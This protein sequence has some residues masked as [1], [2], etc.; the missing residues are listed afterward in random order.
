MK[1][2]LVPT[3]F[4]EASEK[5]MDY[6]IELAKCINAELILLHVFH[7][8]VQPT[9]APIM[10]FSIDDLEKDNMNALSAFEKKFKNKY[11]SIKTGLLVKPGFVVDE[12]LSV[13]QQKKVDLILMGVTGAGKSANVLLGSNTTFLMKKTK[14]P[15]LVIPQNA[16]FKE[17]KNIALAYDYKN[18]IDDAVMKKFIEFVTLFK[19]KVFVL[20]VL[21]PKTV[22][23]YQEAISGLTMENYLKNIDHGLFFP[24]S[25]NI[26]DEMNIFVD[27]HQIDWLV[28]L[29]QSH[30]LLTGLFHRSN[31]KRM[32]FHTH[33]PLLS[34]H[35]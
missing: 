27:T 18:V 3:D 16:Q 24:E 25:E 29:P 8:P 15:V 33:I 22:P 5:T 14:I 30:Q 1:K 13:V 12:I 31:T 17:I 34:L 35:Q 20:D 26:I 2:I 9:E 21:K 6:A 32:A 19:S 10:F 28:M 23:V 4:S 7:I 11:G